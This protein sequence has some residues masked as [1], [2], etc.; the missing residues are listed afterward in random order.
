MKITQKFRDFFQTKENIGI[1]TIFGA[2]WSFLGTIIDYFISFTLTILIAKPLGPE[3]YGLIPIVNSVADLPRLLLLTTFGTSM[4]RHLAIFYGKDDD[5]FHK[6][7]SAGFIL[8]MSAAVLILFL[9]YI[10]ANPLAELM[11]KPELRELI[12]ISGVG[13]LFTGL[14]SFDQAFFQGINRIDLLSKAQIMNSFARIIFT[15][16]LYFNFHL[17]ISSVLWGNAFGYILS[18]I[19]FFTLIVSKWWKINLSVKYISIYKKIINYSLPLI[20]NGLAFYAYTRIDTIIL[21]YYVKDTAEIGIFGIAS[22]IFSVFLLIGQSLGTAV[23]PAVSFLTST[24]ENAKISRL[25]NSL[26]FVCLLIAIPALIGLIFIS[27]PLLEIILPEYIKAAFLLQLLSPLVILRSLGMISSGG[28][29]TPSGHAKDVATV[30]TI[31]AIINVLLDFIFIPLFGV[32]GSVIGTLIVHGGSAIVSILLVKIRLHISLK[33]YWKPIISGSIMIIVM[34]ILSKY[35]AISIFVVYLLCL[36]IY[37]L[38]LKLFG[39]FDKG[40]FRRIGL[41]TD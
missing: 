41:L 24:G 28:F 37:I 33:I 9:F 8:I 6:A 30:T 4:S 36:F 15:I 34:F 31:S 39:V 21:G 11:G 23:F 18:S 35:L 17:G 12:Q 19:I 10:L 38:T 13:I 7:T 3:K 26:I 5:N 32:I 27:K 16:A 14:F 20:V 25:Y 22:S 29:L 2:G 40:Y 1:K